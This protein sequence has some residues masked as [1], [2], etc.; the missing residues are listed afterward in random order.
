MS[1]KL[2]SENIDGELWKK[3]WNS[4]G[5]NVIRWHEKYKSI[6]L[7]EVSNYGRVRF[8][9]INDKKEIKKQVEYYK[10]RIGYLYLEG[11]YTEFPDKFI[12]KMV[13]KTWLLKDKSQ[14]STFGELLAGRQG[15]PS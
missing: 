1:F 15:C 5:K 6:K 14:D 11:N 13:A 12:Y 10:N 7:I 9:D 3:Y 2:K 4:E 8:T